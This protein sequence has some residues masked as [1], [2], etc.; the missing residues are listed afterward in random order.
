MKIK[1]TLIVKHGDKVMF[2]MIFMGSTQTQHLFSKLEDIVKPGEDA[3]LWNEGVGT[4]SFIPIKNKHN[5]IQLEENKWELDV[6]PIEEG[7]L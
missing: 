5:F 7:D 6:E 3:I 4:L 1:D 2:E